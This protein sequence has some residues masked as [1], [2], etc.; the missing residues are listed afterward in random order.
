M[1]ANLRINNIPQS[2]Y[3]FRK[4]WIL[5]IFP[6]VNPNNEVQEAPP[7]LEVMLNYTDK[8]SSLV[9]TPNNKKSKKEKQNTPYPYIVRRPH[10]RPANK[11]RMNAKV[12][13]DPSLKIKAVIQLNDSPSTE[14]K[15]CPKTKPSKKFQKTK[16]K[17]TVSK[18]K[19]VEEPKV[20]ELVFEVVLGPKL[21]QLELERPISPM[22]TELENPQMLISIDKQ[23]VK[24]IMNLPYS[25]SDEETDKEENPQEMD[26]QPAELTQQ[27]Q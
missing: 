24:N 20:V 1:V 12:V 4:L 16:R 2:F 26:Q 6:V 18:S 25:D 8:N 14:N 17:P 10:T 5:K 15:K 9:E 22:Q 27:Q 23:K 21:E 19:N 3:A 13:F 11:L 7:E